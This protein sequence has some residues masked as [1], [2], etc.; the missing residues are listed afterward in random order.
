MTIATAPPMI[1]NHGMLPS[2]SMGIMCIGLFEFVVLGFGYFTVQRKTACHDA[3]DLDRLARG[4][5]HIAF[6]PGRRGITRARLHVSDFAHTVLR[7]GCVNRAIMPTTVDS[8]DSL[9]LWV[10]SNTLLKN[11]RVTRAMPAPHP[12][13]SGAL[14]QTLC[15]A[16]M[17]VKTRPNA[18]N[19]VTNDASTVGLKKEIVAK[20]V[21]SKPASAWPPVPTSCGRRARRRNAGHGADKGKNQSNNQADSVDKRFHNTSL[22]FRRVKANQSRRKP[23]RESWFYGC[24]TPHIMCLSNTRSVTAASI[25]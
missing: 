12:T 21:W 23:E 15:V 13:D 16:G 11:Q 10:F 1:V 9:E 3:R 22:V 17:R 7:N 20:P 2:A 25:I 4:D 18:P 19:A 8:R 14:S 6:G 5:C 24:C